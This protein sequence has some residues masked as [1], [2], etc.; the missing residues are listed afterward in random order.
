MKTM[1]RVVLGSAMLAGAAVAAHAQTVPIP[2]PSTDSSELLFVVQDFNND[3]SY[4]LVLSPTVGNSAGSYFTSAEGTGSGAVAGSSAGTVYGDG[5]FSVS[6]AA[7][8]GLQNFITASGAANLQ[9]GIEGA[10]YSGSTVSARETAGATLVV[11]TD[12]SVP[13]AFTNANLAGTIGP[14]I[15]KDVGGT[16][17]AGFD[18]FDGTTAGPIGSSDDTNFNL[19]GIATIAQGASIGSSLSLYGLTTAGGSGSNQGLASLLGT[20]SFN[21][22]TL[23][24]TGESAAAVPIPAAGWLLGSGL[25]GLL[26][27]A[28][29]KRSE[30]A[31][32]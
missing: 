12:Q 22:T 1:S 8:T 2:L 11:S 26:G 32:A 30:T 3:T 31:I 16:N 6:L 14:D 9:W 10:A 29:R 5:G 7:D 21:G 27:I 18:A 17:S 15:N 23:T 24:F 20:A 13:L 4:T 28:R 25:L 19:Y